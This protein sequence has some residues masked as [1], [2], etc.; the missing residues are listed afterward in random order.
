[1]S[2]PLL[3]ETQSF[4]LWPEPAQVAVAT[5]VIDPFNLTTPPKLALLFIGSSVVIESRQALEQLRDAVAYALSQAGSAGP[6]IRERFT[7]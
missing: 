3:S 5:R 6:T 4:L 2:K 1:M 7:Q